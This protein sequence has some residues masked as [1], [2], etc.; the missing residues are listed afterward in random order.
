MRASTLRGLALAAALAVPCALAVP[1]TQE[2]ITTLCTNADGAAHC[3]RLVEEQQM[4]R[5]PNLARRDGNT[6]FVRLYPTGE[7]RF[8]DV[9]T[10][11]GGTSY[12]LFDFV[13]EFNA[14]V[15]WVTQDDTLG[16]LLVLRAT[17][18]QT[19]LPAVPVPS[20]DRTRFATAD[21]C[22]KNCENAL[23]VWKVDRAGARRELAWR[24]AEPWADASVQWLGPETL[25]IEYTRPGDTNARKLERKLADSGWT[26]IA[27][28]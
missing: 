1:P 27:P 5:L 15:L 13:N 3:G 23:V 7:A 22:A 6:L 20:P 28:P 19:P 14:A 9:D 24:P 10:L 16:F 25:V 12:A 4:K 18:Q 2:E 26:R 17:G 21:F 11:S 8:Q